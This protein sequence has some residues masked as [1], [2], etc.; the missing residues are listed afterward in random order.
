MHTW[1]RKA[2]DAIRIWWVR[3]HRRTSF[4]CVA[5]CA[6]DDDPSA[7]IWAGR[8]VLI[9]PAKK[10]K[11]LCFACPCRCGE[12][13]SLNLMQTHYPRWVVKNNADGT[14]N[15]SPSVDART[16]GSHFWIRGNRIHWV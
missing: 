1:F 15:V 11:W 14:L 7:E 3:G 4:D 2:V 16:C 6:S 8:L 13:L 10:P 9:G 5:V 12:V